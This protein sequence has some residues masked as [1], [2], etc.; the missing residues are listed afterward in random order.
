ML[1]KSNQFYDLL[2]SDFD[3][4]I[5]WEKRLKVEAPFFEKIFRENKVKKIL[6]L[7][8]GTGKHSIFFAKCGY[9][10]TGVDNSRKMIEI[11]KKSTRGLYTV[12]FI[13]A[14]FLVVYPRVKEKFDAIICLG[15]SLPHLLSKNALRKTLQ[16]IGKLLNPE[17]I[18][19]FQNRNYDKILSQNLR[20][21]SPN[22]T[23]RKNERIIFFRVLDF[24]KNKIIFNLVTYREK[25][26][27][28]SFQTKS[29]FLRP[30]MVKEIE[31]ILRILNFTDL[32]FFGDYKSN[33]YRK[34]ASEDLILF[35]RKG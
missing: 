24:C 20:F 11:A 30:I 2:S 27:V 35:A 15:N 5:S 21:M 17:G 22:I 32:K 14:N 19:I 18:V 28:W 33:P 7:A 6:D 3:L 10:V 34:K 9:E 13:K 25:G 23:F 26:G 29:T 8:C 4:M 31:G 16:N 12:K 1:L